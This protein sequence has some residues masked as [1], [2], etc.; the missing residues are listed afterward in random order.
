M[1]VMEGREAGGE[2]SS[3]RSLA[4][5]MKTSNNKPS[6]SGFLQA[7]PKP[8]IVGGIQHLIRGIKSLSQFFCE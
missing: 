8:N 1:F 7:L 3:S 2:E 6:S 5:L 4:K